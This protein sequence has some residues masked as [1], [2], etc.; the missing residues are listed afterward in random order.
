MPHKVALTG[1]TLALVSSP[2]RQFPFRERSFANNVLLVLS[3]IASSIPYNL[4]L[5]QLINL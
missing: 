4:D 5:V 1:F 2:E 3:P